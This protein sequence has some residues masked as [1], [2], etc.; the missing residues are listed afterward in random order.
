MSV[1]VTNVSR[2]ETPGLRL[3]LFVSIKRCVLVSRYFSV[4]RCGIVSRHLLASGSAMRKAQAN[5]P[6]DKSQ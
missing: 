5:R 6:G 4:S 2:Q 3:T 1:S